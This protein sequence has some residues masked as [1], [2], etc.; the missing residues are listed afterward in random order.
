MKL[1]NMIILRYIIFL[2][3]FTG[4][5]VCLGNCFAFF[6]IYPTYTDVHLVDQQDAPFPDITLCAETTPT[7]THQHIKENVLK[8]A[9]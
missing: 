6:F 1:L 4:L 9:L 8:V 7:S 2:I 5:V 3:L